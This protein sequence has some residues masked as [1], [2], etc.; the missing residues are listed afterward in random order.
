[1]HARVYERLVRM[2][3][4]TPPDAAVTTYDHWLRQHPEATLR[5]WSRSRPASGH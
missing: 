4:A 5:R 3:L 1:M 2:E